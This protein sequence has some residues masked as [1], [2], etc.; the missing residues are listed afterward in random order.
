MEKIE[1][2]NNA[3]AQEVAAK[4]NESRAAGKDGHLD[5]GNISALEA[6]KTIKERLANAAQNYQHG[7]M[8]V[9]AW[10][11]PSDDKTPAEIIVAANPDF[12]A[13]IA[14]N[15]AA[16]LQIN[17]LRILSQAMMATRSQINMDEKEGQN[18]ER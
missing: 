1:V 7:D 18:N 5:L 11:K 6:E 4:I 16:T 9:F 17:P 2:K 13:Y 3:S 15:L 8:L 10:A 12:G 14:G